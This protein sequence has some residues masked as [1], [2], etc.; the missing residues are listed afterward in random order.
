MGLGSI[1][2]GWVPFTVVTVGTGK[3]SLVVVV[4]TGMAVA[5]VVKTTLAN[6]LGSIGTWCLGSN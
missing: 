1:G 3:M 2:R 6:G 5:A 4:V